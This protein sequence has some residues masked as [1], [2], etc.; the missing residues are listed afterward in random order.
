LAWNQHIFYSLPR[1][2]ASDAAADEK[3]KE[4][5][6]AREAARLKQFEQLLEIEQSGK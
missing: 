6:K 3:A 1:G 2:K 5:A 4:S